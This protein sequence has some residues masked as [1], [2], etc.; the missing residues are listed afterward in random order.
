[1]RSYLTALVGN[2]RVRTAFGEAIERGTL[3]HAILIEGARGS[4]KH[5]LA[6][7]IAAALNCER[8]GGTG[9]LPCHSCNNCRRIAERNFPDVKYL[10]KAKDKATIGVGEVALFKEDMYLSATEAEHKVYIIES[11]EL[12]TPQAQNSLLI[13]LEEPPRGVVII[14]LC[15]QGDKLL[16]TIRSR[17]QYAVT[18]R[19]STEEMERHLLSSSAEAMA[20]SRSDPAK[21]RSL[22]MSADGCIGRA[23]ELLNPR[24]S[25]ENAE[26]RAVTEA[27]IRAMTTKTSYA[28]L[29]SATSELSSKRAELSSEL[30][31]I[32]LAL[33]DII[34][35]KMRIDAPLLFFTSEEELSLLV[36]E[37]ELK[38]LFFL[39]DVIREAYEDNQ[40]NA[41]ITTLVTNMT[42]KIKN[43]R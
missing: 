22:I 7:E 36:K 25:E 28:E 42:A 9:P 17:V 4:G 33:R 12:L 30:E 39:F 40:K 20:L 11:S 35:K 23:L 34:A 27:I 29:L 13:S 10:A 14:L 15:E 32:T 21:L 18:S 6:T 1:M 5:T 24:R 38:R 31:S 37:Y 16:T 2:D 26:R 41:N 43:G 8:R 3:S 19:F